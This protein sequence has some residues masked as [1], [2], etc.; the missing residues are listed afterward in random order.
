MFSRISLFIY[1][2]EIEIKTEESQIF[3]E[4]QFK[5]RFVWRNQ[6]TTYAP[7]QDVLFENLNFILQQIS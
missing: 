1:C 4:N 7:K 2:Y 5:A 6:R 3:D